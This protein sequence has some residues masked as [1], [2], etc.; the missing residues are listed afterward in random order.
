MYEKLIANYINIITKEDIVNYAK[1]KDVILTDEEVNIIYDYLK[2]Y[3]KT[4][5]Q[6]D[7]SKLLDELK[8]KLRPTT[9]IK[10]QELYWEI[11]NKFLST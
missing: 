3:W 1:S 5:Y 4:F 6:G 11:K 9:F 8:T 7:A 10:L 2:K